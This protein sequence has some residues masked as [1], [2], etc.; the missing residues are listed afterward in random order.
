MYKEIMDGL[1]KIHAVSAEAGDYAESLRTAASALWQAYQSGSGIEKSANYND[2][3]VAA[4]YL[5]RY[6]PYYTAIVPA[7]LSLNPAAAPTWYENTDVAL[8]GPGPAPELVGLAQFFRTNRLNIKQINASLHDLN[9]EWEAYRE[10]ISDGLVAQILP[11]AKLRCEQ[12]PF[13]FT[14]ANA[15]TGDVVDRIGECELI[16]FQN[17]INECDWAHRDIVVNN[18]VAAF[19]ALRS[20]SAL[21]VATRGTN[22]GTANYIIGALAGRLEHFSSK[23]NID[24]HSLDCYPID[25]YMTPDILGRLY[26]RTFVDKLTLSKSVSF[27]YLIAKR[28]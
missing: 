4:A 9:H 27:R 10:H 17:C 25:K 6:F 3:D 18:I 12:W 1:I 16:T 24:E 8:F 13:D 7:I 15:I 28:K 22:Y 5:L 20:G 26:F 21:I 19:E 14:H 2:K 11:R 23:G